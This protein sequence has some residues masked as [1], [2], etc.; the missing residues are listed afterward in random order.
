MLFQKIN[1]KSKQ[2]REGR[3]EIKLYRRRIIYKKLESWF[4]VNKISR[5]FYYSL[6]DLGFRGFHYLGEESAEREN[7]NV[8]CESDGCVD[9]PIYISYISIQFFLTVH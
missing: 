9:N 3:S 1:V 5:P 7:A 2:T 4:P 8:L 6:K